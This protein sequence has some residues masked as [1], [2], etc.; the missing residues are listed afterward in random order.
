MTHNY[1]ELPGCYHANNHLC[2]LKLVMP[3]APYG[4]KHRH[5]MSRQIS[6]E[7]LSWS[8]SHKPQQKEY[9]GIFTQ[10]HGFYNDVPRSF[11]LTVSLFLR[12]LVLDALMD[13]KGN[14]I[15][16][17]EKIWSNLWYCGVLFYSNNRN[18]WSNFYSSESVNLGKSLQVFPM[19]L[20]KCKLFKVLIDHYKNHCLCVKSLILKVFALLV[21]LK[22]T[23]FI[24][25]VIK[26]LIWNHCGR[27]L[28]LTGVQAINGHSLCP[29]FLIT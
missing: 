29:N 18:L 6:S 3:R 19:L 28:L 24:N 9:W 16:W 20:W 23:R 8:S 21:R 27:A 5:T 17:S 22:C 14:I 1:R 25:I 10:T 11:F 12:L 13:L 26:Y 2:L 4:V 7:M 15:L